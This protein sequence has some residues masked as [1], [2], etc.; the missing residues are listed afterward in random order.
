V[1]GQ[2]KI[3]RLWRHY[4]S[5]TDALIFV[6]DANDR[7]RIDE[8]AHE[9]SAILDSDEMRRKCDHVLVYANKMDLP[10]NLSVAEVVDKMGLTSNP[11]L[12]QVHWHVQGAC[13]TTGQG[14][15]E[16]LSWLSNSMRK[17]RNN[18]H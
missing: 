2:E 1:G 13:A 9:M 5:G 10:Q 6:V 17:H 12:K 11:A 3:R 18:R 14:L 4:F 16:G 15:Y 8:A 7:S